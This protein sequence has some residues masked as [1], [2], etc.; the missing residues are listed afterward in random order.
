[1]ARSVT[2][3]RKKRAATVLMDWRADRSEPTRATEDQIGV[4]GERAPPGC[5]APRDEFSLI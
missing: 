4:A 5:D 1:M 2:M 3:A